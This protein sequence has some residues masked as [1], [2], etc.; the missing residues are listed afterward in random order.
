MEP[1]LLN[2]KNGFMCLSTP[3]QKAAIGY[4]GYGGDLKKNILRSG[5]DFM[6]WFLEKGIHRDARRMEL[7]LEWAETHMGSG[8]YIYVSIDEVIKRKP[9]YDTVYGIISEN[10]KRFY[11]Q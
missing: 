9:L 6:T 2:F 4:I 1:A 5:D 7:L 11:N 3:D 8:T 10:L